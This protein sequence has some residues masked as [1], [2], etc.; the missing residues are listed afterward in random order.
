MEVGAE[1]LVCSQLLDEEGEFMKSQCCIRDSGNHA[2]P[3][4]LSVS[5][6]QVI[7]AYENTVSLSATG[8]YR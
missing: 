2:K 5:S 4:L 8:F 1:P 7:D 6:L 3:F